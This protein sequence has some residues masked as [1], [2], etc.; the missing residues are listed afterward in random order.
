MVDNLVGRLV[1]KLV[2][3]LIVHGKEG[4]ATDRQICNDRQLFPLMQSGFSSLYAGWGHYNRKHL[5]GKT[6]FWV[7][8][9]V[10]RLVGW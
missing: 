4:V 10:G 8:L 1:D 6:R 5:H 2:G 7:G 9:L 3:R